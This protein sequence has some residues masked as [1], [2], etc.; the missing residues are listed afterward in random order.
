M[1]TVK[2]ALLGARQ[3]NDSNEELM[4]DQ[5]TEIIKEHRAII[6]TRLISDLDTYLFYKFEFK[7]T[8][9]QA[10]RIKEKLYSLKNAGVEL[11][12]FQNIVQQLLNRAQVHLTN[13]P[14]YTEI[15]EM[16]KWETE[17]RRVKFPVTH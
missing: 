2:S 3:V 9:D 11:E 17:D 13:E 7:P 10:M 15:D 14:F 16:L 6:I 1:K 12:H 5:L 8:K 4:L